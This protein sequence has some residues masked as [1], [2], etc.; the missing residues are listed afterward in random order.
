LELCFQNANKLL[1]QEFEE[2]RAA[3]D[4]EPEDYVC[5]TE[6]LSYV[7]YEGV[8]QPFF[9]KHL[10][11]GDRLM[12]K[13]ICD[14]IER[15]LTSGDPALENLAAVAVCESSYFDNVCE[16]YRDI[17]F[18]C[19]GKETLCCFHERLPEKDKADWKIRLDQMPA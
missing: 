13:R 10:K 9:L 2:M 11:A 7:F 1:C 19:C 5:G 12:L 18:E 15:L 3:Y 4:S 14:F 8:F 17:L 6:E 16:D